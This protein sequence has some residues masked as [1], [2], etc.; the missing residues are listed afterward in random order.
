MTKEQ[1]LKEELA[2]NQDCRNRKHSQASYL[3]RNG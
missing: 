2:K 1:T 3:Q